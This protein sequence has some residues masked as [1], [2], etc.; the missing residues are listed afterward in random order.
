ETGAADNLLGAAGFKNIQNLTGGADDDSFVFVAPGKL[1]GKIDGGGQGAIGNSIVGD[2]AGDSFAIKGTDAGS[3][4]V[5]LNSRF[6]N[7]QNLTGGTGADTF[8]FSG[9]GL[10]TGKIDGGLGNNTIVGNNAGDHFNIT[11]A[12]AGNIDAILSSGFKRIQNL[13]GG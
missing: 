6:V 8:T 3:I 5:L 10:L 4:A 12:N 9:A 13:T 7:V 2:N 11:G 1:T